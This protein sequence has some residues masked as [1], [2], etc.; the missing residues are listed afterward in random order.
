[1]LYS[2]GCTYLVQGRLTDAHDHLEA[3]L[4][5][6]REVGNREGEADGLNNLAELHLETRRYDL[7]RA[8]AEASLA[9]SR[10]WRDRRVEVDA[11]NTLGH[12]TRLL[13]DPGAALGY[14]RA[15]LRIADETGYGQGET[16]ALIGLAEAEIERGRL[17]EAE[18]A[19]QRALLISRQVGLR[20]LEG[21]ALTALAAAVLESGRTDDAERVAR[22]ALA[23]HR[24]CGDRSGQARAL[25]T[26]HRARAVSRPVRS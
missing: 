25:H 12:V 22:E 24:E 23:V 26:L 21:R 6:H 7:A 9:L 3:A 8:S 10:A 1:M 17:V 13:A 20:L 18:L 16:M 4:A 2:L 14:H 11:T 19:L 5:L 15:A